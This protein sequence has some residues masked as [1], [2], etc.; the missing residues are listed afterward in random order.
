V[1]SYIPINEPLTTARFTGLSGLWHPHARS[2]EAF[3]ELILAQTLAIRAAIDEIRQ[4][5]PAASLIVNEDVGRIF[6]TPPLA[7][8]TAFLNERRWLTWDL[9][10]GRVDWHHPLHASLAVSP[11][12]RDGLASL[13][14]RP[15]PPDI[16]GVDH[17][18]TSDRFL[19]HRVDSYPTELRPVDRAVRYVDLEAVRAAGVPDGGLAGAIQDTWDRYG[20][21]MALTEVSLAGRPDDQVAW[22]NEAV[23]VT[24]RA[25]REGTD[26]QAVTAWAVM[27][28]T[29]WH[30]LMCVR[31]DLYE[32]GCFDV[33]ES[34]PAP[35]P[36]AGAVRLTTDTLGGCAGR[37]GASPIRLGTGW[38]HH[39][40]RFRWRGLT[41]AV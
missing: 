22:W 39:D 34:P 37:Q 32:P 38:W 40:D 21:P 28:S 12:T 5:S 36:L 33:R 7:D 25:R 10:L 26:V 17:Y 24:S 30:T 15:C 29:D 1:T 6:G 41:G 11:R 13:L 35:T 16:L 9:L 8:T 31:H 19:D 23:A 18:V 2:E 20:R 14:D 27:G 4:V 3:A